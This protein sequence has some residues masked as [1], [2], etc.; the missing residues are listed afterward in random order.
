M[1]LSLH[2]QL[3]ATLLSTSVQT[4]NKPISWPCWYLNKASELGEL[5]DCEVF[6]YWM[7][8]EAAAL[9]TEMPKCERR[10]GRIVTNCRKLN[11]KTDIIRF[12]GC[13]VLLLNMSNLKQHKHH[14]RKP[15]TG[16]WGYSLIP[17]LDYKES[18]MDYL[19][20]QLQWLAAARRCWEF[21]TELIH[22]SFSYHLK[23]TITPSVWS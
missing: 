3:L 18:E 15:R 17:Y 14:R 1:V 16:G 8:P 21:K 11:L 22:F 6:I 10:V 5:G 4:T 2:Q 19:V 20:Y 23:T 12:K 13:R 7:D 9:W